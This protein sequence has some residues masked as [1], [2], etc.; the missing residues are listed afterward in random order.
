MLQ[1][2]VQNYSFSPLPSRASHSYK[3][4]PH[5]SKVWL[6]ML[7][8][9]GHFS[10]HAIQIYQIY[11]MGMS[12]KEAGGILGIWLPALAEAEVLHFTYN[13]FQLVGL[14]LLL[15][16]MTGRAR[17]WWK[18]AIVAQIWHAYE[19]LLLQ[20]QWLTDFYLFG[21]TQQMSIGQLL[22]PR[23]ELHFIYNFVVFV[24]TIIGVVLYFLQEQKIAAKQAQR[25]N[26]NRPISGRSNGGSMKRDK[27]AQRS[28]RDS[29]KRHSGA[30]SPRRNSSAR[31][32]R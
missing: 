15:G 3:A 31:V 8:V 2:I 25:G 27:A 18:V 10:E 7:I 30:V 11:G 16:G 26:M 28:A 6:Y 14:F 29:R 17:G 1:S 23:A 19:H 9:F 22:L 21:A 20:V 32:V 13:T 4:L 12:P 24:P 5:I